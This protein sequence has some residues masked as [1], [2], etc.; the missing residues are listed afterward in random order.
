MDRKSQLKDD[1]NLVKKLI[2]ALGQL[3]RI[4]L[5]EFKMT[6]K[7]S[8]FSLARLTHITAIWPMFMYLEDDSTKMSGLRCLTGL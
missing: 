4:S 6:L 8:L 7:I 2:L 5:S 1:W 3:N